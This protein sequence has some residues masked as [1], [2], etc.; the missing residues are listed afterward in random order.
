MEKKII[1]LS[2]QWQEVE[3]NIYEADILGGYLK[4]RIEVIHDLDQVRYFWIVKGWR[5]AASGEAVSLNAA[6]TEIAKLVFAAL[7]LSARNDFPI[8]WAPVDGVEDSFDSYHVSLADGFIYCHIAPYGWLNCPRYSIDIRGYGNAMSHSEASLE[9]AKQKAENELLS[10]VK[11][12]LN[13][14]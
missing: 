14:A 3:Q 7:E 2:A 5:K 11:I 4:L 6:K 8:L 1:N 10:L 12:M 13:E 9:L